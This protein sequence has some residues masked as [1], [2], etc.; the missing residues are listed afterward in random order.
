MPKE[1]HSRLDKVLD[2]V[3]KL[4]NKVPHPAIIF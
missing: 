4:G 3:E 1:K 2:T